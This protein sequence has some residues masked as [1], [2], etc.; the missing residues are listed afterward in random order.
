MMI[1]PSV[2]F[3]ARTTDWVGRIKWTTLARVVALS[4]L[5]LFGIAMDLG[6]GPQG[7]TR[8]PEIVLYQ[9][10]TTF[11]V[12][13]FVALLGTYLLADWLAVWVAW[14]TLAIDVMLAAAMVAITHGT[15]S[16]FLFTMPLAV[17][18][19]AALLE[20]TGAFVAASACTVLLVMIAFVDLQ[21][22]L[23]D[24]QHYTA[25]WLRS[26]G[27]R[28][29]PHAFGVFV[30][31][32]VQIAALYGT[33]LLSSKFVKELI[34]ARQR[35]EAERR[36]LVALRVRYEDVVSS[37]P[38]GL[39]TVDRAGTITSCNPAFSRILAIGRDA[40]IGKKLTSVLPELEAEAP[41][42]TTMEIERSDVVRA[43]GPRR[44]EEI[45]RR[46]GAERQILAVKTAN[47]HGA[48]RVDGTVVILRDITD[49]RRRDAE[50][51]S[52]ERLAAVGEM[53]M[54]VAHEIRNPLASISGAV[55][56]LQGSV[57][58]EDSS[59]QLMEIAVR[60]TRHLSMWIGDFLDFARPG[61]KN[62]V[63]CDLM[64]IVEE[65]RMAFGQ[66]PRV[67]EQ[68]VV[69]TVVAEPGDYTLRA[70]EMKLASVV[71]NLL[72]NARQAVLEGEDRRIEVSLAAAESELS[73]RVRDRGP[74]VPE[75]DRDH[76]FE[77]FYT[78]KGEGTGLGLALVRRIVELH[79]G[80]IELVDA[81]GAGAEFWVRWPRGFPTA[82][83]PQPAMHSVAP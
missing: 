70:D 61:Q 32:G 79:N 52:R 4:G 1:E 15:E 35:E 41:G 60:E 23:L 77:P 73:M 44:S 57:E 36:E 12:L 56:M 3:V 74:G 49:V 64:Q 6:M 58:A 24:M 2:V 20:R 53:A 66:D 83:A 42:S 45:T 48:D 27:P 82:P 17:L 43:L 22:V 7:A 19:G 78:T 68:G 13:S 10:V 25:G 28:R 37:M 34:R 30:T 21:I 31:M 71:W 8:V 51:R 67:V 65:K 29:P 59:S 80:S 9:V 14:A 39:A 69:L 5:L 26:I 62:L 54:A 63:R 46:R 11:F 72:T 81:D 50:H 47:L 33:A 38:D 75:D 55:Q 76:I 16:V 40:V 18:S